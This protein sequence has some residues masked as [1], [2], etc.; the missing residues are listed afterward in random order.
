[1]KIGDIEPEIY[2]SLFFFAVVVAHVLVYYG[3]DNYFVTCKICSLESAC[4]STDYRKSLF[5]ILTDYAF[6]IITNKLS[7]T[8]CEDYIKVPFEYSKR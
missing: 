4:F 3:L 8:A 6:N 7:R 1:M 5:L 2:K